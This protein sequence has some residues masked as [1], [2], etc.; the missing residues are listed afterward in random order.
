MVSI[1]YHKVGVMEIAKGKLTISYDDIVPFDKDI[2]QKNVDNAFCELQNAL[3]SYIRSLINNIPSG[4]EI[5]VNIKLK[6]IPGDVVE[7]ELKAEENTVNFLL[8][9]ENGKPYIA[10]KEKGETDD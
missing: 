4:N 7:V 2:L 9:D 6:A 8:L 3:T 1:K 10:R 5:N